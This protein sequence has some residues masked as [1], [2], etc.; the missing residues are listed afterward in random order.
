MTPALERIIEANTLLSGLGFETAVGFLRGWEVP[1]ITDAEKTRSALGCLPSHPNNH[2]ALPV[3]SGP[4]CRACDPQR[5]DQSPRR[6]CVPARREGAA[7]GTPIRNGWLLCLLCTSHHPPAM[8]NAPVQVAFGT[9]TQLVLEGRPQAELDTVYGFCCRVGLPVTLAQVGGW[10]GGWA[11]LLFVCC[12]PTGIPT[13]QQR[14]ACCLLRSS[15]LS[16]YSSPQI[17]VDASDSELLMACAEKATLPEECCHSEPFKVSA[18]LSHA[19]LCQAALCCAMLCCATPSLDSWVVVLAAAWLSN[20]VVLTRH[21]QPSRNSI[22]CRCC[23]H[24]TPSP[25]HPTRHRHLHTGDGGGSARRHAGRRCAGPPVPLRRH[26]CGKWQELK[27]GMQMRAHLGASQQL[28]GLLL[29]A[30]E[31]TVQSD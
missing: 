9:V 13:Q 3:P 19:V 8:V 5:P 14:A 20:C 30:F 15:S 4:L 22:H 12:L 31:C 28:R 11:G 16:A 26:H 17:G 21:D 1:A 29:P 23:P 18:V 6:A 25:P 7:A 10:V 24:C 2:A 27:V